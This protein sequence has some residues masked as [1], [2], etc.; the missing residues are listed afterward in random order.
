M[1]TKNRKKEFDC[2]ENK[3]QVQVS[4]YNETRNMKNKELI[5]YFRNSVRESSLGDWWESLKAKN[6][7]NI[8]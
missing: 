8:K 3:W 4:V 6:Y 5:E 7:L 1:I 2:L